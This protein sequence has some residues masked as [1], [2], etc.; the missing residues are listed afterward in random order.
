MRLYRSN[1]SMRWAVALTVL[2][3]ILI[4]A[5]GWSIASGSAFIDFTGV[6]L[7]TGLVGAMCFC[8][9]TALL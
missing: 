9:G 1:T 2:G 7:M 4:L 6:W 5:F 3:A 8:L